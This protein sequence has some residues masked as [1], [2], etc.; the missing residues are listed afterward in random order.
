MKS[1]LDGAGQTRDMTARQRPMRSFASRPDPID[2]ARARRVL[3][4]K[5][6]SFGDIV[7][8]TPCLRAL[9]QACPAAE[10]LVAVD[11][12]W[13]PVLASDPHI[14]G[15][16]AADPQRR[17]F[18]A[19]WIDARRRLALR[20]G[21]RFDLAIDFQGLSRS[22]AW[23]YASGARWR[24]GRG[25]VR[26]GWQ[27]TVAPDWKRHAVPMCAEIAD[28]SGV[29][30][31][32]LEPRLFVSA[33]AE[34]SIQGALDAVG[35]PRSGFVLANPFGRW[36]SKVWPDERW[37]AF[38]R[39]VHT[40]IGAPLV[41]AGGPGEERDAQRLLAR[42]APSPPPSLA[43]KTTLAEAICLYRRAALVVS[44]DSGPAHAAAAV[45]TP[46]VALFGPTWPERTGPWGS[47]HRVIQASRA[48]SHDAYRNA[49]AQ[50]HM[51]AIDVAPVLDAVA[52]VYLQRR[53][54]SGTYQ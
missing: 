52:T 38:I 1:T 14:D 8:V 24:T 30:V 9:R 51:E 26:P 48:P 12:T 20:P 36:R 41:I 2:L 10:I 3:A 6:S 40:E 50:R 44:G 37:A 13:A 11:R 21:P 39:R 43:G 23:V 54:A 42:L 27:L 16:I 18:P 29:S 33:A 53:A 49:G 5:L 47:S 28:R 25:R 17:L 46:V 7:H 45:G 35:A 31:T 22:A 15:V 19:S 4:V 32:D 34:Q